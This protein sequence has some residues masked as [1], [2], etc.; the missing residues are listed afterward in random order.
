MCSGLRVKW[1]EVEA[2]WLRVLQAVSEFLMKCWEWKSLCKNKHLLM[3]VTSLK[4][5]YVTFAMLGHFFKFFF[6]IS[7]RFCKYLCWT[8]WKKVSTRPF[9][10]WVWNY[11]MVDGRRSEV[12]ERHCGKWGR[13][14]T[15]E[16]SLLLSSMWK[17]TPS[18]RHKSRVN[19]TW[20]NLKKTIFKNWHQ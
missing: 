16:I 13:E 8:V 6:F 9:W 14:L 15:P 1:G 4:D 7:V 19:F 20:V 3:F 12:R 5:E 10:L 11:S 18:K 2:V 17:K